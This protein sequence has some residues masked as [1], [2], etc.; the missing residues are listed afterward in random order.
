MKVRTKL[1]AGAMAAGLVLAG[2][3]TAEAT[4]V[5]VALSLTGGAKHYSAHTAFQINNNVG[6]SV[7][8]GNRAQAT[9]VACLNCKTVAVAVQID[10][11]SG[12]VVSIRAL[13][14]AVATTSHAINADTC[15][16]AYQFIIAPS[17]LVVFST[18][19]KAAIAAVKAAVTAEVAS[20]DS[21]A[22]ITATVATQ[23]D[24][25]QSVLLDPTSY[26]PGTPGRQGVLPHLNL[27]RS[28]D[29]QAA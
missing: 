15:A 27:N 18:A 4:N 23:M 12:P 5:N 20:A 16:A 10:L 1:A 22:V 2:A 13:N 11:A 6:L 24:A 29:N 9:S 28:Q 3:G 14:K 7:G 21:C 17:E 19:G 8:D 26:V 25:L